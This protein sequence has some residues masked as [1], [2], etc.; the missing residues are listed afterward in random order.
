MKNKKKY[1]DIYELPQKAYLKYNK[2]YRQILKEA[3]D[4]APNTF[5]GMTTAERKFILLEINLNNKYSV[6]H[7]FDEFEGINIVSDDWNL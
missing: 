6:Y 2:E 7:N 4:N 3:F 1:K 5:L